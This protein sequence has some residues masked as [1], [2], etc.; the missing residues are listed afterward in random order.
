MKRLLICTI[1][2][3][4]LL[5]AMEYENDMEVQELELGFEQKIADSPSTRLKKAGLWRIM[6]KRKEAVFVQFLLQNSA[7]H[8]RSFILE[9]NEAVEINLASLSDEFALYYSFVKDSQDYSE[10]FTLKKENLLKV[11]EMYPEFS[12]ESYKRDLSPQEVELVQS[13]MKNFLNNK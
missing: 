13:H 8:N 12:I 6:N 7:N 9:N 2:S 3:T 10:K 11:E 5:S 4:F 1:M